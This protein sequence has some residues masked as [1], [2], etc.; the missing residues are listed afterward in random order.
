MI[1][2]NLFKRNSVW[3]HKFGAITFVENSILVLFT[4]IA[5]GTIT[6]TLCVVTAGD[7]PNSWFLIPVLFIRWFEN[8]LNLSFQIN[9]KKKQLT[10]EL[11]FLTTFKCHCLV[12]S[13]NFIISHK[14]QRIHLGIRRSELH[15]II[16]VFT[17][18]S[19]HCYHQRMA[20]AFVVKHLWSLNCTLL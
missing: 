13:Q 15:L 2:L 4:L 11:Y 16:I 7:E 19:I 5:T 17:K 1:S 12:F 20:M 10:M 9:L 3:L 18:H 14:L 6:L 8:T